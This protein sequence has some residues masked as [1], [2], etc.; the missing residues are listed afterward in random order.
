[1]TIGFII[2][3][4]FIGYIL[5]DLLKIIVIGVLALLIFTQ[6]WDTFGFLFNIVVGLI[7][8]VKEALI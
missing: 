1:M 5:R 4:F 3:M 8:T 6:G 2:L 7:N